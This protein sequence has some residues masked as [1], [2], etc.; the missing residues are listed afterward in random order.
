MATKKPATPP[1]A[2]PKGWMLEAPLDAPGRTRD[3]LLAQVAVDGIVGNA[4]SLVDF[5]H[6]TFGELS[7]T[8]CAMALKDTAQDS[9]DGDLSAAV[10]MLSSQAVALNAMFGELARRS[11]LN[12][13][14]YIDA[15]E[16]YMRL[17]LKAQGQCRA[18]LET[19]AAIK[20]PPA[21]FAR[22]ANINNGGQQQVNNGVVA[23]AS[24][25]RAEEIQSRPNELL[26]QQQHGEWL[27]TGT[28]GKA[29]G[30]DPHLEPVGA[31]DRAD[32]TGR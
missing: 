8:D 27:D 15:S 13:G 21:V 23:P 16:R 25:A 12:M 9:N 3:Q 20:N 6:A 17:A 7:L 31:I 22:Q 11:A 28:A 14:E 26:E 4:R 24:P 19:L 30:A 32:V 2:K 29:G 1:P 18:T 5:G 10:T